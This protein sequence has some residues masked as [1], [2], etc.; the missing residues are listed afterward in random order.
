MQAWWGNGMCSR[1]ECCLM[2]QCPL[3]LI[4][5]RLAPIHTHISDVENWQNSIQVDDEQQ[6]RMINAAHLERRST[7]DSE[8][9]CT[10]SIL[11]SKKYGNN[12]HGEC[13]LPALTW[14]DCHQHSAAMAASRNVLQNVYILFRE[15]IIT[16]RDGG[17]DDGNLNLLELQFV[18]NPE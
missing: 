17:G 9:R 5:P 16:S 7:H 15:N 3:Y 12:I 14:Q 11:T 2:L 13:G 6:P 1:Q 10:V 18:P 8:K 4:A